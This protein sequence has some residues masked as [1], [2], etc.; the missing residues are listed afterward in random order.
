[1]ALG[2]ETEWKGLYN[3]SDSYPTYLG[4]IAWEGFRNGDG[5]ESIVDL[6]WE[7]IELRVTSEAPDPLFIEW[8]Y[9]KTPEN[10]MVVLAHV[11][12][13]RAQ[14]GRIYREP[15]RLRSGWWDYGHCL[16]KH[17]KV[18]EFPLDGPEP[19]WEDLEKNCEAHIVENLLWRIPPEKKPKAHAVLFSK[20]GS[21]AI[22]LLDRLLFGGLRWRSSKTCT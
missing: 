16:A 7:D 8:V 10:T 20:E 11:V 2:T 22:Y 13:S 21:E 12:V 18:G 1:M 9:I 3:H 14:W 5:P 4:R 19:D 15:K 17:F 6:R